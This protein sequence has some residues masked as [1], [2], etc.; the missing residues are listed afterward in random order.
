MYALQQNNNISF[1]ACLE[2]KKWRGSRVK[3]GGVVQLSCL[4]V[5]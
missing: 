1:M 4:E 2:V 3:G 5:F